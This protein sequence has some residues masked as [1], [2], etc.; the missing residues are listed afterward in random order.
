VESKHG[1]QRKKGEEK[2]RKQEP[3]KRKLVKR[4]SKWWKG[5][6]RPGMTKAGTSNPHHVHKQDLTKKKNLPGKKVQVKGGGVGKK[7][8]GSHDRGREKEP[9]FARRPGWPFST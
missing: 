1:G 7:R 9:K 6:E 2:D 3:R 5:D 8:S 4:C